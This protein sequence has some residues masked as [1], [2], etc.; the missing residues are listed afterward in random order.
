[1]KSKKLLLLLPL[2]LFLFILDLNI[3]LFLGI[4]VGI[5]V[6]GFLFNGI[7]KKYKFLI[8]KQKLEIA[9]I[10]E[11]MIISSY[12]KSND[13]KNILKKLKFSK[14]N[15]ISEEFSFVYDKINN[16]HN[17]RSVFEIL[18]KKYESVILTRFLDLLLLS[19]TTGV[20]SNKDYKKL[21]TQFIE[22]KELLSERESMLL[23]QKYT[24]LFAG[25]LIVPGILGVVISLI[26]NL[27]SNV[28]LTTIASDVFVISYVCTIIYI[29]EY[30]IISGIYLGLI[31]NSSRKSA[32]Y[33]IILLPLSLLLFF[34][35][36]LFL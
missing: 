26:N 21:A 28:S 23:M 5:L 13:L 33:V 25:G 6:F 35:F 29:I 3:Y 7:F 15:I 18:K 34:L 19:I 10:D 31:E 32:L 1:M 22:S 9:I 16:G 27:R 17:P 36:S 2:L 24:V 30:S 11:L 4:F 14:N 8:K 20:V 12:P